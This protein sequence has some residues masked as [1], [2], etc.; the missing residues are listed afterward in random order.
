M[1]SMSKADGWGAEKKA[2][3]GRVMH[4]VIMVEC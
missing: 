3:K 4:W 1:E 2:E